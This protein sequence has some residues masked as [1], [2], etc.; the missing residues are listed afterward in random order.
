MVFVAGSEVDQVRQLRIFG[1]DF[2]SCPRLQ[3]ASCAV[4]ID[5]WLWN[6]DGRHLHQVAFHVY[7]HD[8]RVCA[9][10]VQSEGRCRNLK[11]SPSCLLRPV[12]LA[13]S[14]A[15]MSSLCG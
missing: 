6:F 11:M 14:A 15:R 8:D 5:S 2:G 13:L 7:C 9:L 10:Q 1:T 12:S 4:E 3:H